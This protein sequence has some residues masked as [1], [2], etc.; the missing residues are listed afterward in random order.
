M[1][2]AFEQ[3]ALLAF[4][5]HKGF[6]RSGFLACLVNGPERNGG[7]GGMM[8]GGASGSG[9]SRDRGEKRKKIRMLIHTLL[10]P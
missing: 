9:H 8:A 3:I 1:R 10:I 7:M 2:E 4:L 5:G 6:I